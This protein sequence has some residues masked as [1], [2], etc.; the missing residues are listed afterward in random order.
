MKWA[1]LSE[2]TSTVVGV[3]VGSLLASAVMLWRSSDQANRKKEDVWNAIK[4]WV[5]PALTPDGS[6]TELRFE[7]P[8]ASDS[9]KQRGEI[10]TCLE[11]NYHELYESLQTFR[12]QYA[13]DIEGAGRFSF[14]WYCTLIVPH[15][16]LVKK[17]ESE[18]LDKH[19]SSLK[20]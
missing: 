3:V 13:G 1:N 4:E 2:L 16:L 10:E 19:F 14:T 8:L 17:F 18:I 20:C 9:K 11:K 15:D 6:T 7:L 12:R 5:K